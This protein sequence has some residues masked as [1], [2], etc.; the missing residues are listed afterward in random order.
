M[1]EIRIIQSKS[2]PIKIRHCKSEMVQCWCTVAC[3]IDQEYQ[4][5]F[6]WKGVQKQYMKLMNY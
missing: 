5:F 6:R 4:I 3:K 2:N 1:I